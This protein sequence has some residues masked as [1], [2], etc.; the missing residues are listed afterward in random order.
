MRFSFVWDRAQTDSRVSDKVAGG[1]PCRFLPRAPQPRRSTRQRP[2]SAESGARAGDVRS[3]GV[4]APRGEPAEM[5]RDKVDILLTRI[6]EAYGSRTLAYTSRLTGN[7]A[8]HTAD[9]RNSAVPTTSS[10]F[11][12]AG[13]WS[14][15]LIPAKNSAAANSTTPRT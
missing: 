2:S 9:P 5:S 8:I 10:A 13:V 6:D 11:R 1:R 15:V 7:V 12:A 3:V 14:L 4:D